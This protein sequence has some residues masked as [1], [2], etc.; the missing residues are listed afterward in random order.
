MSSELGPAITESSAEP[1]E[2]D[3]LDRTE[4]PPA[5]LQAYRLLIRITHLADSFRPPARGT[6]DFEALAQQVLDSLRAPMQANQGFHELQLDGF[7]QCVSLC[8]F[9]L[10]SNGTAHNTRTFFPA[11]FYLSISSSNTCI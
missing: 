11:C 8:S 5:G 2:E 6:K 4:P 9:I 10:L 1:S 3:L 7:S